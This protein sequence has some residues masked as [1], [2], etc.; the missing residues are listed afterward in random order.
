MK[1]L[2][3]LSALLAAAPAA[4]EFEG[5]LHMKFT[6]PRTSGE[7]RMYLSKKGMRNETTF[8]SAQ[9]TM[10]FTT[11]V[12]HD[13]PDVVAMIDDARKTYSE[14]D[15]KKAQRAAEKAGKGYTVKDLGEET[16]QGYPCRHVL[17]VHP[18]GGESELWTNR[19]IL[20]YDTFARARTA[21]G[22]DNEGQ[23]LMKAL[24][25]AGADGFPVKSIHRSSS[26]DK[27]GQMVMELVK[28]EPKSLP[29]TMFRVP[30][31]YKKTSGLGAGV[32]PPEAGKA[33]EE[34]MKSM[35]PEQR[36]MLEKLMKGKG[37]K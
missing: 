8:Q 25:D 28:A 14:L 35:T 17:V 11:L 29:D 33:M 36:A 19:D 24:K 13:K 1:K 2:L 30:A 18:R 12:L 23:A 37:A 22:Q 26:K 9:T 5:I 32:L 6:A 20:D 4:A 31:G 16:I 10:K 34:S 15:V 21:E 7:A 3:L 27:A